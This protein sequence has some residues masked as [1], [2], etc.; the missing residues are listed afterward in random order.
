MSDNGRTMLNVTCGILE[1]ARVRKNVVTYLLE[2]RLGEVYSTVVVGVNMLKTGTRKYNVYQSI[3]V[4]EVCMSEI[5]YIA[6]CEV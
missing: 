4:G 3:L 2:T 5:V 6:S 1:G